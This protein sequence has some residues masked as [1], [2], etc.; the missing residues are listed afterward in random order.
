M[1]NKDSFTLSITIFFFHILNTTIHLFAC[2]TK[3]KNIRIFTKIL[4][5]TILFFLY[6]NLN[7]NLKKIFYFYLIIYIH[8][9]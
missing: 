7:N 2:Y 8:I 5:M 6:K 9:D 4:I 3:N 1:Q